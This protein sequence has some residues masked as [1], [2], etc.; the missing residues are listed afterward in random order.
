[1]RR[2]GQGRR[3]ND[4]VGGIRVSVEAVPIHAGGVFGG[5]FIGGV[6]LAGFGVVFRQGAEAV[7]VGII[8]PVLRGQYDIGVWGERAIRPREVSERSGDEE[9]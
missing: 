9:E 7:A 3:W 5:P 2:S 6:L 1:M 4:E 8:A